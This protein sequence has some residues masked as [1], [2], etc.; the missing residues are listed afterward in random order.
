MNELAGSRI[1]YVYVKWCIQTLDI[2][3]TFKLHFDIITNLKNLRFSCYLTFVYWI[4]YLLT[5]FLNS[6]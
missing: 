6:S 2:T 5:L 1:V 3:D 4:R